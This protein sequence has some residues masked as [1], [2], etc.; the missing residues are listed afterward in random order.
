MRAKRVSRRGQ[1]EVVGALCQLGELGF[2]RLGLALIAVLVNAREDAL[3]CGVVVHRLLVDDA[4][5]AVHVAL[6]AVEAVQGRLEGLGNDELLHDDVAAAP[7]LS[8]VEH[9]LVLVEVT[10]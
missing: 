6:V 3:Q 1:G 7:L 4:L 9:H 8:H 5:G 10:P 2:V